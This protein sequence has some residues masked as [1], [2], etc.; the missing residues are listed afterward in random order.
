[1]RSRWTKTW[2]IT[3]C[4]VD[5]PARLIFVTDYSCV[6]ANRTV[7]F[8]S[9]VAAG[10]NVAGVASC[11]AVT[12]LSLEGPGCPPGDATGVGG[13]LIPPDSFLAVYGESH[14]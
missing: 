5:N 3:S 6:S 13:A 9:S 14:G 2:Y 1:M 7:D 12:R 11:Y 4:S 10:G 8:R